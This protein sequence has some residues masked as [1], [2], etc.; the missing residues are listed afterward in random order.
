M[1]RNL[2]KKTNANVR[3]NIFLNTVFKFSWLAL[4]SHYSVSFVNSNSPIGETSVSIGVKSSKTR[5]LRIYRRNTVI[6][7]NNFLLKFYKSGI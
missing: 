3:T 2:V 1:I 5:G 4:F 7:Q 6:K